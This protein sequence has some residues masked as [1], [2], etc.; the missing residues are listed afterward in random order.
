MVDFNPYDVDEI[1]AEAQEALVYFGLIE[2][3]VGMREELH[4]YEVTMS[5]RVIL[6]E[7]HPGLENTIKDDRE[8]A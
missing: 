3:E 6:P 7:L 2:G 5:G 1:V 4:G 8:A